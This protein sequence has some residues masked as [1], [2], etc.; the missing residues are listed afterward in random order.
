MIETDSPYLSPVPERG[1]E[2]YPPKVKF[3]LDTI[4]KLRDEDEEEIENT[5][6]QN[7]L[8]FFRISH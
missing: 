1:E 7:S 5:I 3:V 8:D 6:Y 2:N 4:K